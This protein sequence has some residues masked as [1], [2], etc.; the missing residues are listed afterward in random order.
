MPQQNC[1]DCGDGPPNDGLHHNPIR[2]N[3][4]DT[5]SGRFMQCTNPCAP[6]P[7]NT[8]ACETLPS[9]IENFTKQF[10]GDVIKTEVD[11]QVQW[12]LPCSL[13]VG[14]PNNPRGATEALGCYFLRLF[15]DG[16]TGLTGPKG[17][18]GI[19]GANGHNAFTIVTHG[20]N[21]PALNNPQIQIGTEFNPALVAGLSVFIDGSGWY[22]IDQA[23]P[24]G[25]LFLTMIAVLEGAL[26]FI[27][28]N[29]LVL[30]AGAPGANIIG[31]PGP[32]GLPGSKGPPGDPGPQGLP[33]P[34][35]GVT[36]NNGQYH[37]AGGSNFSHAANTW[38]AVNFTSSNAEVTLSA[39]GIYLFNASV[40]LSPTTPG[41]PV[42]IRLFNVTQAAMV[43]G[44]QEL[45]YLAGI[46]TTP[47]SAITNT[48]GVNEVIRLELFGFG[49]AY[50]LYTTITWVQLA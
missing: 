50:P 12:S 27:P 48:V 4:L 16:V 9:Q 3:P 15:N 2:P 41:T 46:T 17:Q 38:A 8:A 47:I 35:S 42:F 25:T 7:K 14:L 23:N 29:S 43:T 26:S 20:F 32:S 1:A 31:D 28:V 18:P 36:N 37:D 21:Q 45:T 30:V 34:T 33:S 40:G 44:S 22:I 39:A 13:T 10:F 19:A 11:G 49:S 5:C 24:D 6:D